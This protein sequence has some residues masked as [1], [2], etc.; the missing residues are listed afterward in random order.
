MTE[1]HLFW[2]YF[3]LR[4]VPTVFTDDSIPV[5]ILLWGMETVSTETRLRFAGAR[6][7][8]ELH[9]LPVV[10]HEADETLIR[11][12]IIEIQGVVERASA[13]G[14]HNELNVLL[15]VLLDANSGLC[16]FGPHACRA[17]GNPVLELQAL[18]ERFTH[19]LL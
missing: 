9:A 13:S 2:E 16:A 12:A 6:F 14:Q 8:P 10:D 3:I 7:V 4:F 5:G 1:N 17:E 11:E 15:Q 18:F 19:R